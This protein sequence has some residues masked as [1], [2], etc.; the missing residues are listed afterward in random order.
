M[1]NSGNRPREEMRNLFSF[2]CM[3]DTYLKREFLTRWLKKINY[4]CW[5]IKKNQ[6]AE[7]SGYCSSQTYYILKKGFLA[8]NLAHKLHWY[9]LNPDNW[10]FL[11]KLLALGLFCKWPEQR[12]ERF[13]MCFLHYFLIVFE[14]CAQCSE[15][16]PVGSWALEIEFWQ[17]W[18]TLLCCA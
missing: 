7:N 18:R 16:S 2:T 9:I 12:R 8:H 6:L 11:K 14:L 15:I 4:K 13:S 3:T 17:S 10:C 5:G 1:T